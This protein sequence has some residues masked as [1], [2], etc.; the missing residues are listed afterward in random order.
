MIKLNE[1][2]GGGGL[3]QS[4]LSD[5]KKRLRLTEIHQGHLCTEKKRPGKEAAK[6]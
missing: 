2:I 3:I 1:A 4:D 5:Y 6:Q